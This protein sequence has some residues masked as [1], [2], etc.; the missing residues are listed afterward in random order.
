MSNQ[1]DTAETP[2]ESLDDFSQDFFSSDGKESPPPAEEPEAAET[3]VEDETEATEVTE[4]EED[5]TLATE[6]DDSE[7]AE[8]ESDESSEDDEEEKPKPKKSRAQERIEELNS[9]YREEERQRLALEARLRE[10]E[11]KL[12]EPKQPEKA[13]TTPAPQTSS[14]DNGPSPQDVDEKGELKYP[15]GEFDPQY[16]KDT[17]S[18]TLKVEREAMKQREQEEA[19][20]RERQQAMQELDSQWGEKLDTARERYSD[21]DEK[22][23]QLIDSLG[24]ID[25]QY[26]EYLSTTIKEMDHGAEVLYYLANNPEEAAT[27]I[28]MGA[29]KATI[30][31]GRLEATLEGVPAKK[32]KARPKVSK[33]TPPPPQNKGS[34]IAAGSTVRGD[35]DDLD[36]VARALFS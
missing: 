24:G 29:Q 30:A 19:Q 21:F 1:P 28:G 16:I 13:E 33:A 35:E 31:L 4:S 7:E 15:L 10:L 22:G 32:T 8:A 25:Q 2:E 9:K 11:Q 3:E 14:E 6:E 27:I 23:Q 20:Q 18:H 5:D 12:E 36:A 34:A 17:V 26:G